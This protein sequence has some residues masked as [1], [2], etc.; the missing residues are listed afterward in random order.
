MA[1]NLLYGLALLLYL[2][3]TINGI[4]NSIYIDEWPTAIGVAV[5]SVMAWPTAKKFFIYLFIK[6]I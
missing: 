3:G 6:D 2:I 5:L 1:K 4:G